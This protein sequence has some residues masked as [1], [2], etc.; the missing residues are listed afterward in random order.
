MKGI[1]LTYNGQTIKAAGYAGVVMSNKESGLRISLVG[2][3]P[4]HSYTYFSRELQPGDDIFVTYEDMDV[5]EVSDP[6]S[7]LDYGNPEE[8]KNKVLS[9]YYRLRRELLDEGLLDGEE[10]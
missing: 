5:A 7:I 10:Q 2:C 6:V 1:E 8:V 4:D 3:D 9:E